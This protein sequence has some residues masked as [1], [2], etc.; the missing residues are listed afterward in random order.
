[1]AARCGYNWK[2]LTAVSCVY[3][4]VMRNSKMKQTCQIKYVCVLVCK[5]FEHALVFP[6]GY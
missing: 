2:A 4:D 1:M 5:R 3:C 6:W